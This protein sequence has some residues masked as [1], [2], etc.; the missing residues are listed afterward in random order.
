MLL[1]FGSVVLLMAPRVDKNAVLEAES[2]CV[3]LDCLRGKNKPS[4]LNRRII[5]VNPIAFISP[6]VSCAY[7]VESKDVR[8]PPAC[9]PVSSRSRTP[10][11]LPSVTSIIDF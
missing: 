4:G 11:E 5:L 10:K 3:I 9:Q 1:F 2:T 7:S 8:T 6:E